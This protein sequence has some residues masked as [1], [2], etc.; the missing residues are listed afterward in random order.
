MAAPANTYGATA[1]AIAPAAAPTAAAPEATVD[2]PEAT[3]VPAEAMPEPI[4]ES[5]SVPPTNP[6]T[7]PVADVMLLENAF[8]ALLLALL[9]EYPIE[10]APAALKAAPVAEPTVA[11]A[12][13]A[14]ALYVKLP[15]LGGLMI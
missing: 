4:D 7:A 2:I 11:P 15:G 13:P 10:D 9:S 6:P 3:A 8:T 12:V 5:T 1:T 14:M